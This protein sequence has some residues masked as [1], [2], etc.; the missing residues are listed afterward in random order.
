MI[1]VFDDLKDIQPVHSF[2]FEC[3]TPSLKKTLTF[4]WT[5]NDGQ[6]ILEIEIL[7]LRWAK[8]VRTLGVTILIILCFIDINPMK[9]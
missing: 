7:R 1:I 8:R 3:I 9:L 2:L 6:V 4:L 5:S